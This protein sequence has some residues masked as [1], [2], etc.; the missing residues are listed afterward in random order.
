[1]MTTFTKVS[2]GPT[3]PDHTGCGYTEILLFQS[4]MDSD[5]K[6]P[7]KV[8]HFIGPFAKIYANAF[9]LEATLLC[10]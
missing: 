7:T 5:H 4:F 2:I 8:A 9:M 1:M 10:Q 3:H 6:N